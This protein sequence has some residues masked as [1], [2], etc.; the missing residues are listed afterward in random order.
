[1]GAVEVWGDITVGVAGV[2]GTRNARTSSRNETPTWEI[3]LG[4]NQTS[5][6]DR[7]LFTS[8]L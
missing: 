2:S 6:T 7:R 4:P 8:Q 3:I 5:P 1:M